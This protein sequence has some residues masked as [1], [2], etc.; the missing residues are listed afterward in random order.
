MSGPRERLLNHALE[1]AFTEPEVDEERA[2]KIAAAWERGVQ[3][4]GIDDLPENGTALEPDARKPAEPPA[5]VHR[6]ATPRR[7]AA[8]AAV[9]VLGGAALWLASRG[10]TDP[11]P[12]SDPPVLARAASPVEVRRGPARSSGLEIRA[13]DE[14]LSNAD[15]PVRLDL[16]RGGALT[17]Y[18]AALVTFPE[19]EA[20]ELLRGDLAVE[21]PAA[22]GFRLG[23]GFADLRLEANA[24]V[25]AILEGEAP[26]RVLRVAVARGG[27]ELRLGALREPLAAGDVRIFREADPP[28][29]PPTADDEAEV[30]ARLAKIFP[31]NYKNRGMWM[32]ELDPLMEELVEFLEERPGG[33]AVVER[34]ASRA[35]TKPDTPFLYRET[36]LGVA[37]WNDSGVS[38]PILRRLWLLAPEHFQIDHVL[39]GA[40]LGAFEL[41]REIDAIVAAAEE[42]ER[43]KTSEDLVLAAAWLAS[44]GDANG[45]R[46]LEEFLSAPD[47]PDADLPLRW[48]AAVALDRGG[49]PAAWN[50]MRDGVARDVEEAL[51]AG[52]PLRA[53]NLVLQAEFARDLRASDP[54]RLEFL[55]YRRMGHFDTRGAVV[56][57]EAEIRAALADLF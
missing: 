54:L 2:R 28:P 14:V 31:E 7:V 53:A 26:A 9:L 8:A 5:P 19:D 42:E 1:R 36:Y 4:S 21:T 10:G 50:R 52:A 16:E 48:A 34:E 49:L 30:L 38:L 40:R 51:D 46:I 17:L 33:W 27:A 57:T 25:E 29:V 55:Q 6:F 37:C 47:P 13:G 56:Q 39:F 18:P 44:R 43:A 12:A 24:G 20:A 22:G 11:T 35:L 23:A 15:A 41:E 45:R 3:G 32:E